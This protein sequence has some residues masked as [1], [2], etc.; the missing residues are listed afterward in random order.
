MQLAKPKIYKLQ[1]KSR[2]RKFDSFF[3]LL[4]PVSSH[5]VLDIGGGDGNYFEALYPWPENI[6]VLD[7]NVRGL[8]KLSN[9]IP[10]V[11]NALAL[12]FADNTFDIVFSNAVIEHVGDLNCQKLFA[13][14]LRRVARAHFVTT[15]WKGFP[16]ELHYKLP[17]YQFVPKQL[18]RRLSKQFAI[19][20]YKRG[21]W[22]DI[23]LLWH[24]QFR[25]LFPDSVVIKQSISLWPE[26]LI[27]YK[28]T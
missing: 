9:G 1:Q 19:G 17:L 27:A 12:P 23:N 24:Y 13:N 10:T 2:L 25:E 20:W 16:L 7:I 18:Q 4:K 3:C 21:Q 22:S 8:Q 14:E 28:S 11:G 15:P 6:I 5:K 26:T